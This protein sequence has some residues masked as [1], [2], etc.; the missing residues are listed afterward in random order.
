MA[1]SDINSFFQIIVVILM[2]LTLF[3]MSFLIMKASY[4]V[5]G[6]Y[7]DNLSRALHI[8]PYFSLM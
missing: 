8:S 2:I 1:R 7:S 6:S 4:R 3:P 5:K